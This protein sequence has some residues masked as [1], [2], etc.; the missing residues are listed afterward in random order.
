[1]MT[2][3][4]TLDHLVRRWWLEGA[5]D[6]LFTQILEH[7]VV[8]ADLSNL[9]PYARAL[10]I[11]ETKPL[12]A[13]PQRRVDDYRVRLEQLRLRE[14]QVDAIGDLENE[15]QV[16]FE[17]LGD[18]AHSVQGFDN[19]ALRQ[20]RVTHQESRGQA[21]RALLEALG[22]EKLPVEVA[23]ELRRAVDDVIEREQQASWGLFVSDEGRALAL[24]VNLVRRDSG[25]KLFA[26]A[27]RAMKQQ[28]EI[29]ADLLGMDGWS[30]SIEWPAQFSGES[31]GLPLFIAGLIA[32]DRASRHALTVATGQLEIDGRITGVVNIPAKID[33]ARRIGMR[34]VL[35]PYENLSDAS[36]QAEGGPLII[37]VGNVTDVIGAMRQ[38]LAAR[39]LSYA[40]L[41]RL[42]RASLSTYGLVSKQENDSAQGF[43]FTVANTGGTATIWVYRNSRVS[44]QGGPGT[45]LES[46]KKLVAEQ[47]PPDPEQR[48]PLTFQLPT[49]HLQDR[50]RRALQETGGVAETPHEHEKWRIRLARGRSQVSVILYHSGKCVLQGTA[51]AWDEARAAADQLT[52]AIGGVPQA[53]GNSKRS[54][55]E[56]NVIDENEPH[57]GTD[58]A[59][60]GDYFGPLVSAAVLVDAQGAETLRRLGVRDSKLLSDRRVRALAD[61]IRRLPDVKASVTAIFP[62]KFN[63]LYEQFRREGK[64]LNSLLAWGHARSIETLLSS[65][66]TKRVTPAYVLVDQFA[67]K[68][69]IEE[70]T[71]KAGIPVHQRHKAE[72]DIAVAAASV[73]ARDGFL[74]WL[75]RWSARTQITLPKGASP[76]VIA[77]AKLFV[78]KWGAKW[79]GE[80]AKLN[81]RTTQQVLEGEELNTDKR[82]PDWIR[83]GSDTEGKS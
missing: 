30:A 35:I 26:D 78:R 62:R 59:G 44:P 17:V 37:P 56:T 66:G 13:G 45:A 48:A 39:D 76:Q 77:A 34:R 27:D 49:L 73:L 50:Y 24:G 6:E 14:Y 52:G 4:R 70:R 36:S 74:Q 51:P 46:A 31:I 33:A 67:D 12:A 82:E 54:S 7:A 20:A 80:V 22:W 8:V 55:M 25:A 43:R 69:Y 47:V 64:N 28:A 1:M 19:H 83:D 60:K 15:P 72:A 3:A 16:L 2:N 68:H 10:Q 79:L 81:F 63:E 9:I 61:E 29:A 41:I 58:E 18:D 57:I 23:T 38:P 40:G 11:L 71:R 32:N 53:D 65:A 21:A 5:N 42:I 75:E